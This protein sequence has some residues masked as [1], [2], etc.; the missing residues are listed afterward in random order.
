MTRIKFMS[1]GLIVAAVFVMPATA[2]EHH[3]VDRRHVSEEVN[4]NASLTARCDDG[5]VRIPAAPVRA[6]TAAPRGGND[7]VC[8]FAT[9]R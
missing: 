3:R 6:V 1:V 7:G 8:D 5:R 4:A 9:T 2:R